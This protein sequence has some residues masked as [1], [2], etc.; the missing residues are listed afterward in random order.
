MGCRSKV[1]SSP[2][3]SKKST[4]APFVVQGETPK[5]AQSTSEVSKNKRYNVLRFSDEY[6]NSAIDYLLLGG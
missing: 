6:H 2:G 4:G 3:P 1:Y 5:R